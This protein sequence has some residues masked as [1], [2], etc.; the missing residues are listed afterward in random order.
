MNVLFFDNE[1]EQLLYD[2]RTD[3]CQ[4]GYFP[5]WIYW[6]EYERLMNQERRYSD[7]PIS[8]AAKAADKDA[9]EAAKKKLAAVAEHLADK[10]LAVDPFYVQAGQEAPWHTPWTWKRGDVC[11]AEEIVKEYQITEMEI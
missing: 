7:M 4:W 3:G 8:L 10:L 1:I 6:W 2:A 9:R 5:T 11:Q